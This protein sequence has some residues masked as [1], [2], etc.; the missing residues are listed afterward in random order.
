MQTETYIPNH[1]T[2]CEEYR[3]F[4][5]ALFQGSY[6]GFRGRFE[7]GSGNTRVAVRRLIDASFANGGA[8]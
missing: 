6:R 2:T 1:Y 8:A 3:G 4:V 5:I 7:I